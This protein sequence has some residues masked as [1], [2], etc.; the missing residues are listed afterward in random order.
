[1][2]YFLSGTQYRAHKYLDV[3]KAYYPIVFAFISLVCL[4]SPCEIDIPLHPD[5]YTFV[6][7]SPDMKFFIVSDSEGQM[8]SGEYKV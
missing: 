4:I 7:A 2:A 6:Q 5:G 3:F 1:M 8:P